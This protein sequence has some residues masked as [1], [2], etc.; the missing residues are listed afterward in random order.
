MEL[1]FLSV[2]LG[3]GAIIGLSG[4]DD[5]G[6]DASTTPPPANAGPDNI[7]GTSGDDRIEAGAG[8]DTVDGGAGNDTIFLGIGSDT[9]NGGPGN[10]TI[11]GSG[12][13]DN[14]TGGPGDDQVFLE[15]GTD[16]ST[17]SDIGGIPQ[18]GGNDIIRGGGGN[19]I[20]SDRYG[21]NELYGDEGA[22]T[23]RAVDAFGDGTPDQ[24]FGGFGV[25]LLIGDDGDTMSG[26]AREDDFI[27]VFD[28]AGDG[29]VTI[30]DFDRNT[31]TLTL[32]FATGTFPTF[33]DGDITADLVTSPG[34]ILISVGGNV[35]AVLQGQ[36]VF[37]PAS[38]SVQM[39]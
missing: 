10:D 25:D 35:V 34:N 16:E 12:G 38:V 11:F 27:G 6:D 28:E 1:V 31:E 21:T 22:D 14:V 19:D 5:G 3:L 13:A 29:A 7:I 4:G 2:L 18:D 9:A 30:T 23:L 36:T 39:I 33:T 24:L 32:Q 17:P 8:D 20:L 26:G 15:D 37:N